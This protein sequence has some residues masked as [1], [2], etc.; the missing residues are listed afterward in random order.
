MILYFDLD[1]AQLITGPGTRDAVNNLNFKRGDT[2]NVVVQFVSGLVAQEL[3]SGATGKLGIKAAG[4]YSGDYLA[5]DTSWTKTGTGT[6]TLYTFALNLATAEIN[7]A[8]TGDTASIPAILEL[9]FVD[10]GVRTSSQTIACVINNDVI[11]GS[12]T[13]PTDVTTGTPVNGAYATVTM[14]PTGSNNSVT[15]TSIAQ[16]SSAN[17]ISIAYASPAAA[18]LTTVA[19]TGS[20]IVVTPATKANLTATGTTPAMAACAA[21]VYAGCG[22]GYIYSSDGVASYGS[23]PS[24]AAYYNDGSK[25]LFWQW[26][27]SSSLVV[28]GYSTTN[29]ATPDGL[30]YVLTTGTGAASITASTTTAAQVIAAVNAAPAAAALVV[31]TA[32]GTVT[33]A[34]A[35]LSP[36]YLSGGVTQTPGMPGCMAVDASYIYVVTPAGVWKKTALSTL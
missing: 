30:T 36:T 13:G 15:Y 34:V 16:S 6:A 10:T 32:F 14:D 1:S 28:A 18:A 8:L 22:L 31:A 25:W 24:R 26:D 12:E 33:G 20:A 9:E 35:A 7:A 2:C 17:S 27:G 19:V 11:K 3:S 4:N 21:V 5:A 23:G 29:A